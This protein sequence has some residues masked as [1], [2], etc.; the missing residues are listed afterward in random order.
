[1]TITQFNRIVEIRTKI[2]SMASFLCGSTYAAV[3]ENTW[4]WPLFF[5]M[6]FAILF[7]D[8]GT[9]GFNT[10]FDFISGTD[11]KHYNIVRD[12][13][14]V[15]E[16][17]S[18]NTALLISLA[19]FAAAGVLGIAIAYLTSWMVLF[20]GG[21]SMVV[22]YTYTGGPFP[23][24]RTPVGE[25]FAGGFLGSLL[26]ILCYYIQGGRWNGE[27]FLASLPFFL[28]I[29]MILT[30]NNTCD[31]EADKAAGRK[32]FSILAG[33]RISVITIALEWTISTATAVWLL[34]RG[35]YPFPM[36]PFFILSLPLALRE[37]D[38]LIKRGFSLETKGPSMG[39]VSNLFL[40]Y[41][42]SMLFG[43]LVSLLF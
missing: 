6:G 35:T 11:K 10:Y 9:T 18:P 13:V 28:L 2:I 17:V 5:L 30:V 32:T 25:L 22:G 19:L 33:Y 14:L 24:S 4:S 38:S 3:M 27:T 29:A 34:L 39:S 40:L 1:M 8:M 42:A 41:S 43:S 7:V 20:V 16:G 23:I 12:K 31:M 21:I 15:H 36:V 26:F 37:L